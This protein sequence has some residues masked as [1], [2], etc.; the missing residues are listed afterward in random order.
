MIS[1]IIPALN[2]SE[3]I[4]SSLDH[5]SNNCSASQISEIIVVDGG[6]DDNTELIVR[7]FAKT[8]LIKVELISSEKG[9]AKQMNAGA[10]IANGSILY[11]LHADSLPPKG[12]DSQIIA[13]VEKGNAAGCFR[14]R[15]DDPHPLLKFSEWFTKFNVKLCRGGDQSLFVS[16]EIFTYLTGYDEAYTIYED[17]EFIN[18]LYDQ[19]NFTIIKD[20]VITSAR[21]YAKNGAWKL[22]YHFTIIHLKQRTGASP[23]ELFEYY[24]RHIAS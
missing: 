6:S 12:F 7:S 24:T 16:K 9:R 8:S 4:G 23:E 3:T 20:Y 19:F 17:C 15:F 2:E 10:K 14:M 18:R 13:Q 1:I 11:F 5:V 21:K 22:Q